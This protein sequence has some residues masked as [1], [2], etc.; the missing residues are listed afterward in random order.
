MQDPAKC[1]VKFEFVPAARTLLA[2]ASRCDSMAVSHRGRPAATEMN[3]VARIFPRLWIA[4][5]LAACVFLSWSTHA[6]IERIRYVSGLAGAVGIPDPR[7]ATGYANGERE[8]IIPERLEDSFHWIAQTEQMLGSGELRV[9]HVGYENPPAGHEVSW[10]SPYRWWLG[11]VA[12]LDHGFSGRPMGMSVER[13]ALYADPLL[14]ALVILGGSA[15]AAW[16]LG[17][18]TAVL[19]ALGLVSLFPFAAHFLPGMP[20]EA[21]LA[22]AFTLGSL[23]A[24]LVAAN[25]ENPRPWM[26]VAGILGGLNLWVSVSTGVPIILGI[27]TGAV[28]A[29]FIPGA[30][31]LPWR[32]WSR[33]GGWTVFAAY[34]AEYFPDHMASWNVGRIHPLYG[35]GWIGLGEL[36]SRAA[37]WIHGERKPWLL[38]DYFMAAFAAVLLASVPFT[39]WKT[40]SPGFLTRDLEWARLAGLPGSPVAADSGAWLGHDGM[41]ATAWATLLP[42]AALIAAVFPVFRAAT[43]GRTRAAIAIAVGPAVVTLGFALRQLEWWAAFDACLLA[44]IAAAAAAAGKPPRVGTRWLLSA[45]LLV[46]AVPGIARLLPE[47]FAGPSTVLTP[48]ESEELVERHLAHWLAERTG[49]AGIVVY[50]PPNETTTLCYFG[51]LRGVGSF[52]PDNSV[53]FGNA[54]A[55][56]GARTMEEVQDDLQARRVRYIVIPSWDPFFDEFAQRYLVKEFAGRKSLL[57]GELQHWN[58]PP[59]LQ[60]VPYQIPVGGGFEG[61]SV[62]V[63][64]VVDPQAP[65]AAAGRLAEYLVEMGKLDAAAAV[66]ERLRR[67]PG[68]VGALAA[69]A[70]VESARGDT[71]GAGKTLA[72]LLA[73]LSA[74]GDRFLPWDRRVSLAVVLVRGER[75]DLARDQVRRCMADANETRLRS[76]SVGSL[77]DLLVL[78]HSFGLDFSDPA[79]RARALDLLPGDLRN[80]I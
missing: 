24:V 34:L 53:G 71:D 5:P 3:L 54:L 23:L 42:V 48:A 51:G 47:G 41:T 40:G 19:L 25:A 18:F 12:T 66:A 63:F 56:A 14:L 16:R 11:L 69:Q 27:A 61:Q 49:E 26:V 45:A 52:A 17:G 30:A 31:S 79:L 77:Y 74:G 4:A 37:T 20:D 68:D 35:L 33:V 43:A 46:F 10:A 2:P 15:F 7:S 62:L 22:L 50:A 55:I 59:W 58:L 78:A 75:Y 80:R 72:S 36:V 29:A 57:I 44:V 38:R 9:R 6:R 67:Y 65:A 21:G 64:E 28:F 32:T 13:A 39:M 8:L 60:A 1:G 70:Q 76:L 73:R